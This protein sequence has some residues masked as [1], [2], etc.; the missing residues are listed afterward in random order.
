MLFIS[1]GFDPWD[2]SSKGLADLLEKEN[3]TQSLQHQRTSFSQTNPQNLPPG[4]ISQLFFH[5]LTTFMFLSF[6]HLSVLMI[7]LV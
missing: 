7:F 4:K 6:S 3:S 5:F 2:E 1:I